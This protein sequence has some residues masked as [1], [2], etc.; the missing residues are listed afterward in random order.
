MASNSY[1]NQFN[2][3]NEQNLY[4]D[5]AVESLRIHPHDM[6]YLPRTI[7]NKDDVLTEPVISEFTTAID[8]ELYIQSAAGFEGEGE[9]LSKFGFEVRDQMTLIMSVRSF[10]EFIKP[11][12]GH[13]KP[14]EG[15]C[16]YVP[17]LKSIFQIKFAKDNALW[18][19]FGKLY[20]YEI[21]CELLEFSN[22]QFKTGRADIDAVNPPFQH[23][24]DPDYNL[25]EY[26]IQAQNKVIQD[27]S[28]DILDWT[29]SSPFGDA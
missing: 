24:D 28:D 6:V 25:E 14:Q 19:V 4:D 15:D 23:Y 10:N 13:L 2:N 9:L 16:I 12:T 22:E 5:L 20:T 3:A 17:M 8:I 11:I 26:D 18:Y 29:E 27:E 1:F 7:V 21:T